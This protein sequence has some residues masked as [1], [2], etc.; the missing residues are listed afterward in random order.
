MDAVL[1]WPWQGVVV[2]MAAAAMLRLLDRSRAAV[3]GVVCWIALLVVVVLPLIPIAITGFAADAP[4]V[5]T[6]PLVTAPLVTV[7]NVWWTSGTFLAGL[8]A[9]WCGIHAVRIARAVI[10]VRRTRAHGEP[11]PP[12]VAA[13]LLHWQRLRGTGRPARLVLSD[14]VPTAA[15]L[16]GGAPV[17]AV[18]RALV[19]RLDANELDGVIVHEWAHVQRRD[20]LA[21]VG[22]LIVRAVMGWHPA[23]WW[24]DRRL[25]LEQELACDEMVVAVSGGAKSYASCLVKLASC[26]PTQRDVLLA[27]GALSSAGIA[28]RIARLVTRRDFASS[29]WSRRAAAVAASLLMVLALGIAPVR[30]VEASVA[31]TVVRVLQPVA[32]VAPARSAPATEPQPV[33]A[34]R[35]E[36]QGSPPPAAVQH[37]IADPA[38]VA[39]LWDDAVSAVQA[40]AAKEPAAVPAPESEPEP[41]SVATAPLLP[42]STPPAVASKLHVDDSARSAWSQ[43]ADAGAAIGRGSRKAGVAT[44]GAFTRFAKKIAGSF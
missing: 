12:G 27:A 7:P 21:T 36:R 34:R 24:L 37:T 1:N 35:E 26:R 16:G 19:D 25:A 3:R 28:R 43:A 10:V 13:S 29:T 44:A 2:A 5:S 9:I 38:P 31:A 41:V 39:M 4:S 11:F 33:R 15:V 14:R 20:D 6:A 18:A 17:I 40:H 8:W 32:H 30:I 22:R 42:L 23:A